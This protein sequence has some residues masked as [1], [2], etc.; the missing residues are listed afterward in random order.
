[1][2]QPL[3]DVSQETFWR[4]LLRWVVGATP[5]RVVASTPNANLEDEGHVELRAEVR[6]QQYQPASDAQ[7]EAK[8]ITPDGSSETVA[9]HPEPLSAG[10]YAADWQALKTGSYVAE[11]TARQAGK[12]LGKDALTFRRED[13][14]AENFH[15]EQNKELLSKLAEQTGGQYYAPGDAKALTREI[16]FSEAG[17]T[18]RE[19]KEIWDMPA[20]FLLVFGSEIDRVA[21]AQTV[22][23]GMKICLL[24]LLCRLECSCRELLRHCGW[25]GRRARIRD[26]VCQMGSGFGSRT[27]HGRGRARHHFERSRRNETTSGTGVEQGGERE[28]RDRY[29]CAVSDWHGSFDGV[30]YKINLPGPDM[31]GAELAQSAQSHSGAAAVGCEYDELQRGIA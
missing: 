1:M 6:D 20:V 31:T 9:L 7:V 5:T 29:V 22:G 14:Q 30:D 16:S 19:T 10:V 12:V 24:L 11:V 28:Q 2:Q 27:K 23:R 26:A 18:G 3:G 21:V 8:I 4:Q 15:R 25:F 13:G 17:I